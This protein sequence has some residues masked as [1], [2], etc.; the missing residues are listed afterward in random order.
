MKANRTEAN[1]E[2]EDFDIAIDQ[3]IL[4][5]RTIPQP[6]CLNAKLMSKYFSDMRKYFSG[7]DGPFHRLCLELHTFY[8]HPMQRFLELVSPM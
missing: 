1:F 6:P 3:L 8:I 5:L 7:L 4:G 2:A